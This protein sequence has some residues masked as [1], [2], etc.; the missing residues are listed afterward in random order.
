MT[1]PDDAGRNDVVTVAA[2]RGLEIPNS[3]GPQADQR[4]AELINEPLTA[5][6]DS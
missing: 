3:Q 5:N 4:I 2:D 1:I 6:A